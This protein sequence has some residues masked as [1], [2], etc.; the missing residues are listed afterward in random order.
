MIDLTQSGI[1][2]FSGA[3]LWLITGKTDRARFWGSVLGLVAQPFWIYSA[4]TTGAWGIGI[5]AIVYML[6]YVRGIYNNFKRKY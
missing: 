3:A 5:L 6:F 4:Y 1:L 2:V